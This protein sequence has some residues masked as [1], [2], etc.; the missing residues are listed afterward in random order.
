MFMNYFLKHDYRNYFYKVISD[1]CSENPSYSKKK[2]SIS[3]L[4]DSQLSLCSLI[5]SLFSIIYRRRV[6]APDWIL[7]SSLNAFDRFPH[8][9]GKQEEGQATTAALKINVLQD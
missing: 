1:I 5:S 2:I 8:C 3:V 9:H 4:S 6:G 7:S